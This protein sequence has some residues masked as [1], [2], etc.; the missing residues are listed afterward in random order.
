MPDLL[1][2]WKPIQ[3]AALLF[4][5]PAL[6]ATPAA[7]AQ[8]PRPRRRD[9]IQWR[10]VVNNGDL[11]PGSSG[12]LFNSYNQPSIDNHETVVFRARSQGPMPVHGIYYRDMGKRTPPPIVMLAD[13]NT[14]VPDPNN[15]GA[16]FIEFP[17]FPRIS[18]RGRIASRGSSPP[19]WTYTLPDSTE[20]R[21]GTTDVFMANRHDEIFTALTQLGAVPG[22]EYFQVPGASTTGIRFDVF[23]GAP[24]PTRVGIV[25]KGNYTDNNLSQTG[26]YFRR[27]RDESNQAPIELIAN[28]S[29]RIPNQPTV[30]TLTFGSTAPPSAVGRRMVFVGLDNEDNPTAGGIYIA[31]LR[32]SPKLTT[33][34]G[35]G[36]PVPGVSGATFNKLGEGL[37]F[38]GRFVSFWGAW[39]TE[40]RSLTLICPTDGN[41]ARIAY[42]NA[43]Y[44]NGFTTTVPVNQGIFVVDIRTGRVVMVARTGSDD[45]QDFLYWVFSGMVPGG[46]GDEGGGEAD[47]GEPARWRASAFAAISPDRD[48]DRYFIAFKGTKTDGTQGIYETTAALNQ[49]PNVDQHLTLV[50]TNTD[51]ADIDPDIPSSSTPVMV[52]S[53]GIERDGFRNGVLAVALSMANADSSVTWAGL[54]ITIP[55]NAYPWLAHFH[56]E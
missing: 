40:T 19:V 12:A 27:L 17:S 9:D 39:G 2:R 4:A 7:R 50:D 5:L 54:Y 23:P 28:T 11:M 21:T 41:A 55:P 53:V 16:E 22:F 35:I 52:T 48:N 24:S 33:L 20:T 29:T 46:D 47:D 25:F 56:H 18:L 49:I 38:N 45:F 3:T 32:P 1:F 13:R 36:D 15:L 42:C 31:P 51:G 34:V 43:Q 8:R 37:S 14:Q 10:T 44:P 30:G 6:L 26:V